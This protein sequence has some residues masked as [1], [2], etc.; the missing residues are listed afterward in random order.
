MACP[1]VA[2]AAALIPS[3]D[4]ELSPGNATANLVVKATKGTIAKLPPYPVSPNLLLFRGQLSSRVFP[5]NAIA[6]FHTS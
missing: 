3:Q 4:P 1:H 5:C 6:S 2:G